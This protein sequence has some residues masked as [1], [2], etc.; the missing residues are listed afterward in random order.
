M[1][2]TGAIGCVDKLFP[3]GGVQRHSLAKSRRE[4]HGRLDLGHGDDSVDM[5]VD[6]V[7]TVGAEDGI[8]IRCVGTVL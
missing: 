7:D 3:S 5:E 6:T 1:G 2:P 4:E 8:S